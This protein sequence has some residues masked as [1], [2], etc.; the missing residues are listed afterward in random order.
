MKTSYCSSIQD[1]GIN[2]SS[3]G[4]CRNKVQQQDNYDSTDN[5]SNRLYVSKRSGLK[6][7]TSHGIWAFQLTVEDYEELMAL[8]WRRSGSY[9]YRPDNGNSCCQ[10]FPIRLEPKRFSP[11]KAQR[12][13][14]KRMEAFL[15]G[16]KT[17]SEFYAS[18]SDYEVIYPTGVQQKISNEPSIVQTIRE[19][20]C[21]VVQEYF[22]EEATKL[23][24][25]IVKNC[26]K[27]KHMNGMYSSNVILV[28]AGEYARRMCLDTDSSFHCLKESKKVFFNQLK[29]RYMEIF[30]E[31]WKQRAQDNPFECWIEENGFVNF[32]W[33]P[34]EEEALSNERDSVPSAKKP[35]NH[36]H[37]IECDAH[38]KQKQLRIILE[39][40]ELD[41]EA[42]QVFQ[43]YQE[44]IHHE[45]PCENTLDSYHRFLV[46]TPLIP[47]EPEEHHETPSCG[48]GTFHM[49]YYID[50]KLIAVGVLDILPHYLSSVYFFYDPSYSKLSLGVLSTLKEIEWVQN[51]VE[52]GYTPLQYY[53]MGFYIH[54]CR[55]MNYKGNY[56]PSEVRCEV[57]GHWVPL[58][59]AKQVLDAENGRAL[60]LA[61]IS[62]SF[63]EDYV[64]I[65]SD[66]ISS[67][68]PE[69]Q[70][71][72]RHRCWM[73]ALE[74][75]P[76]LLKGNMIRF[77]VL[78][79]AHKEKKLLIAKYERVLML[80]IG[81][82]GPH[83][84]NCMLY[85]V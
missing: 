13:V 75:V 58:E 72:S 43:R 15:D 42:F 82:V 83:L 41:K 71:I 24:W 19:L 64:V 11:T 47:V 65:P 73:K 81:K 50:D 70:R 33:L 22:G 29:A 12:K 67:I 68:L 36:Q 35:I 79:S 77:G 26:N 59:I 7:R 56:S 10:Q 28:I 80:Y 53:C 6:T 38:E 31:A 74:G 27:R 3:C 48:F 57:T 37:H 18:C 25:T 8:G 49:K 9:I 39:R 2:T 54:N 85:V 32:K 4:Y 78:K 20:L 23:G 21:G 61:P 76:M 40:A 46:D 60:R 62:Y 30:R 14:V 52:R 63:M 34:M 5:F 44:A 16:H 84:S 66:M 69:D 45:D 55:K 1:L 51:E 17:E